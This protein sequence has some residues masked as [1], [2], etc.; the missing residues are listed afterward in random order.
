[1]S[2][3]TVFKI[4]DLIQKVTYSWGPNKHTGTAIYLVPILHLVPLTQTFQ[5]FFLARLTP[6]YEKSLLKI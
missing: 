3:T 6:F 4:P 2:G 1:M 5:E